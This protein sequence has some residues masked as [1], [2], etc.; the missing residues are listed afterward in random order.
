MSF[1][2]T[3][4]E[5]LARHPHKPLVI[6]VHG[7]TTVPAE[8]G[9]LADLVARARG[10]L[11]ERGVGPGDRVALVAPNSIRWVAADLACLFEGAVVVPLYDRQ[12]PRELGEI[13]AD[14]TPSLVVCATDALAEGLAPHHDLP[15]LVFEDLFGGLT[16]Q[17]PP[18]PRD[19][20]DPVTIIYTSGTSGRAKG[21]VLTVRNVDFMLPQ[22]RDALVAMMGPRSTDDRVFHYLPF[23]FAGSRV[24]LWTCLLRG[25]PIHVSTDLENLVAELKTARPNYFLN[26][27]ML[28]E[29]MKNGVEARLRE[30]PTPIRLLYRRGIEGGMRRLEGRGGRRDRVWEA[31][32]KR[33]ILS[34]VKEQ[35]GPD[36]EC[37]I[38]GSAPLG[39][40]TQRWFELLGVP[41]YQ[42]YGLTETTAIVTM[43]TPPVVVPG[44]VGKALPGVEVKLGEGDELLVRGP[45]VFPTY[46]EDPASTEAA[47]V[48]GWFRT[49][50]QAEVDTNGNWRIV[51]RVKNLLV[52]SSGHNVA[53]EP[54]EQALVESMEGADAVVVVGHGRPFLGALVSGNVAPTE[55]A[56]AVERVN[57]GLPHYRRIRK[58][59]V[60]PEPFTIENGML[61][62]N[63]KLR[64]PAIES[65]YA[66]QI[67][68]FYRKGA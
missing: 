55:A 62:A 64:R 15:T 50:D 30:R 19:A 16:T 29:R 66:D 42:V 44:R 6:E 23:C 1:L 41:V 65:T 54:I 52:P 3:F 48:D 57:E 38:C 39:E 68:A 28:L 22:T 4:A 47:F 5:Q 58:W 31:L 12:E 7:E 35:I 2:E 32:V 46:W 61:T 20:D 18:R 25:N 10:T 24:V 27:P 49:G 43:D 67:D 36:L 34:K 40:V 56:R 59:A 60:V 13:L 53:P 11:R 21:V 14:C 17:G 63:R 33:L 9:I 45:N 8:G 51:G 37:L 26:V